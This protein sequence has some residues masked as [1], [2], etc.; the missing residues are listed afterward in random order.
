MKTWLIIVISLAIFCVIG[1]PLG[2]LIGM[3][4]YV[5]GVFTAVLVMIMMFKSRAAAANK[6]QKVY[7]KY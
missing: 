2:I 7:D 3:F 5:I 1:I 6:D 4:G